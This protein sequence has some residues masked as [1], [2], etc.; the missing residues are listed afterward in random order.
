MCLSDGEIV[1]AA[2]AERKRQADILRYWRAVEYFSPP[3]VDRVDENA[4]VFAASV[5]R[6]LPWEQGSGLGRPRRDRVWRHTVYAGIFDIARMRQFLLREFRAPEKE[7]DL[8]GR[9]SGHSAL[10]SFAVDDAGHLVRDSA[11]L[12]SCGWAISRTISPGPSADRWLTGFESE[13]SALLETLLALGDNKLAVDRNPGRSV[14]SGDGGAGSTL[15]PIG[16]VTARLVLTAATGAVDGLATVAGAGLGPIAGPVVT[17]VVSQVGDELA[18]AAVGK[19]VSS[20]SK[21]SSSGTPSPRKPGSGEEHTED[22]PSTHPAQP[23]G[24]DDGPPEPPRAIG[25]KALDVYDLAA[26]TRWVAE[27]LGVADVLHPDQI[28][29]KSYQ[30]SAKN[31]EDAQSDEILNSFYA[32]D[33]DLIGEEILRGRMGGALAEYLRSDRSLDRLPRID[34]R[35]SP[36]IVLDRLQPSL[37][38]QGRWPAENDRPLSLS[39]QFAINRIIENLGATDARGIY[40]V[41]GPPGT[42]KTT[43]LRDLIA[44]LV[45]LRAEKL[46]TLGSAG[47]AFVSKALTWKTEGGYKPKMYPLRPELT[48]FEMVL[49]SSNNGAVENVTLEVPGAKAVGESW[50]Q[51]ADYLSGPASI[52]LKAPAWGAIAARLGKRSNRSEFVERFWWCKDARDDEESAADSGPYAGIGLDELLR[53]QLEILQS[54]EAAGQDGSSAAPAKPSPPLG[55]TT[56]SEAKAAFKRAQQRVADLSAERQHIHQLADRLDREDAKLWELCRAV[57]GARDL[58]AALEAERR[59]AAGLLDGEVLSSGHRVEELAVVRV[60]ASASERLVHSALR[61]VDDAER[62]LRFWEMEHRRP[63]RL[64]RKIAKATDQAWLVAR[65]PFAER[66]RLA[67]ARF[68]QLDAERIAADIAVRDAQ[69][70]VDHTRAAVWNAQVKLNDCDRRLA[71]AKAM[72]TATEQQVEDRLQ[73]LEAEHREIDAARL[74]WGS[75]VPGGEWRARRGDHAAMEARELS[76]PWMDEKFA[77]ARTRLFLAALDLHRAVLANAPGQA[78]TSLS[79]AMDVVKGKVPTDLPADIILAAWQL[80]FLVVPVVSTTFASVGSMFAGLGPESFGW[81]IVDEAGQA[82]PQ[83]VV[84][85]LW[86]SRRAVVVGDPLQLEP[87]VTLP[88]TG[89]ARLCRHFGVAPEWVPG[90]TSV[91]ARSDRLV[92]CGTWLPG[93]QGPTWVG[94]PLRVHRRCDRLMFEVSNTIA[95]DRMMVYGAEETPADYPILRKNV[96]LNINSPTQGSAKWNPDEGKYVGMTLTTIR[97]RIHA[98]M[99]DQAQDAEA[100]K[101]WAAD[102]DSFAKEMARRYGESVFVISPFRE[103]VDGLKRVVRGELELPAARLGTVHK[104]QGKEADIVILVLGTA[105]SQPGSR[106]WASSTPNLVNVAVTRARRRLIVIGDYRTWSELRFF[107]D[108]AHHSRLT[109]TDAYPW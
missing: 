106:D 39:Q 20:L 81:L 32:D 44:A 61:H 31:A 18:K 12:S 79:A 73:E 76:A 13:S 17:K 30:V 56:W 72:Q 77:E 27:E 52:A 11:T 58:A 87:V 33:L 64:R 49:A 21:G 99:L 93:T 14:G 7:L 16:G 105:A 70:R 57:G 8:D 37:M 35:E 3:K 109:V 2:D 97:Q 45:V 4:N 69:Y 25:T 96:W 101:T 43:M 51:E 78:R 62:D 15:G 28:R 95:Y 5:S 84:G 46:A 34:V 59:K 19:V 98:E 92:D 68:Q 26:I 22:R 40:A 23:G 63:G 91:Q 85:A 9:V 66:V 53:L 65:E 89:Q 55:A 36:A 38:P 48:G 29:I 103:V 47:D 100:Q 90:Y 50:R 60:R 108:L 41:N 6:P 80:L 104:T 42:G 74:L 88:P 82:P 71:E 83:A 1:T 54:P 86:R 102:A 67:D 75:A 24:G 10:L 94:S 107:K